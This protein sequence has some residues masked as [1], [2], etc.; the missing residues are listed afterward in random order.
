MEV[1]SLRVTEKFKE[2]MCVETWIDQMESNVKQFE[3]GL[4]VDIKAL[5]IIETP[6][7]NI[8]NIKELNEK[9]DWF[10]EL[11]KQ[12]K[13]TYAI[14][15]RTYNLNTLKFKS[16]TNGKWVSLGLGYSLL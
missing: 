5:N 14:N 16:N 2:N 9:E 15:Q 7:N 10:K 6:Y 3:K 8:R 1:S 4:Y 13:E 12:L 11:K